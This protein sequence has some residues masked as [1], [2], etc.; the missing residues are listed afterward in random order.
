[1]LRAEL[2]LQRKGVGAAHLAGRN[3]NLPEAAG[4]RPGLGEGQRL[5]GQPRAL[6]GSTRLSQSRLKA[7]A[8]Q[9]AS[10]HQ[11]CVQLRQTPRLQAELGCRHV[12]IFNYMPFSP[13]KST[14]RPSGNVLKIMTE[15]KNIRCLVSKACR[16]DAPDL[17]SHC[18]P[19]S[20]I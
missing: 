10:R 4:N 17:S 2:L 7:K 9:G 11:L 19:L 1:M 18:L 13:S 15:V 5:P 20:T 12:F 8:Q 3:L 16:P 14:G 6:H